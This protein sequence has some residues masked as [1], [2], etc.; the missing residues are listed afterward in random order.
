MIGI[1]GP[2]QE[3]L[4]VFYAKTP[5]LVRHADERFHCTSARWGDR[6]V[7][8]L[9][10][11]VGKV[12]A[13]AATQHLLH[14]YPVTCIILQGVAGGVNPALKSGDTVLADSHVHH[15]MDATAL[16]FARGQIPF[17]SMCSFASD[18]FLLQRTQEAC[19]NLRIP[20]TVGRI[21][22][23][24]RFVANGDD[25]RA[26]HH[27]FDAQAVDM[28]GA[29]VAQ[30]C[31][32]HGIPFLSVKTI[33]DSADDAAAKDFASFMQR[34]SEQLFT[35]LSHLVRNL[36]RPSAKAAPTRRRRTHPRGSC[37]LGK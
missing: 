25:V 33:S 5:G 20:H 9:Q 2:M 22:S 12:N 37:R 26:L 31:A 3:E 4:R 32:I 8:F 15:D 16:G 11:G 28:E 6:K 17:T 18:P 35:L 29:A 21:V 14:A 36:P 30:V 7:V 1:I 27:D 10:C 19:V 23:G 13:A 34:S 24:D